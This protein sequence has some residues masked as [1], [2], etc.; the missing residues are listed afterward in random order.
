MTCRSTGPSKLP[1]GSIGT[2]TLSVECGWQITCICWHSIS[3]LKTSAGF[4]RHCG[5]HRPWSQA[6]WGKLRNVEWIVGL[7]DARETKPGQPGPYN[8]Q[9]SN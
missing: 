4:I 7:I 8:P 1:A 2:A 6:L 5:L 3:S 9:I